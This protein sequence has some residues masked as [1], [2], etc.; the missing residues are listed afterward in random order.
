MAQLHREVVGSLPGDVVSGHGGGRLELDFVIL[1]VFSNLNASRF[2]NWLLPAHHGPGS[3]MKMS[4]CA[5]QGYTE[6]QNYKITD[7]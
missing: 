2:C 5:S 1:V 6:E 7:T 4:R 3:P